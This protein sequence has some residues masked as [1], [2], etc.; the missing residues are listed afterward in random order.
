MVLTNG[1]NIKERSIGSMIRGLHPDEIII[2]DPMKEFT[3]SSI[4]KV[5]DWFWVM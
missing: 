4:Q 2:D 3:M 5:S 1:N